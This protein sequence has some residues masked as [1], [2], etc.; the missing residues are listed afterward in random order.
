MYAWIGFDG[1]HVWIVGPNG[2]GAAKGT[3]TSDKP[4]VDAATALPDQ[5]SIAIEGN[6]LVFDFADVDAAAAGVTFNLGFYA[7]EMTVNLG[8]TDLPLLLGSGAKP[9]PLPA[10]ISKQVQTD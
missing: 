9:S 3:I 2:K 10:V 4:L 5:G 6:T 7:T 8:G 1:W